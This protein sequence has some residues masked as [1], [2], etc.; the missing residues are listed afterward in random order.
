MSGML[1]QKHEF[2]SFSRDGFLHSGDVHQFWFFISGILFYFNLL[3][4]S[5]IFLLITRVLFHIISVLVSF[6]C[7]CIIWHSPT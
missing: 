2:F 1:L 3:H 7:M 6:P 4:F 5:G